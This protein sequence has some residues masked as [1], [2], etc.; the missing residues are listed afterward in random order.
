MLLPISYIDSQREMVDENENWYSLFNDV[1]NPP[2]RKSDNFYANLEGR[3]IDF[4]Y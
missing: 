1:L 2:E 3:S 4:A